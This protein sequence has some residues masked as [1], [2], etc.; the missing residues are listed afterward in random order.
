[1][2]IDIND[3]KTKSL[4]ELLRRGREVMKEI[5]EL[6]GPPQPLTTEQRET[7]EA[8]LRHAKRSRKFVDLSSKK[9]EK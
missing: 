2:T 8:E 7:L 9:N 6:Y 5:R 3:E 4:I 1:M